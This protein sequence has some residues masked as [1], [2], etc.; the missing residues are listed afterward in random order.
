M[1]SAPTSPMYGLR[2]SPVVNAGEVVG[3]RIVEMSWFYGLDDLGLRTG[4]LVQ[5]IDGVRVRTWNDFVFATQRLA[6]LPPGASFV[7][8]IRRDQEPR[9]LFYRVGQG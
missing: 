4:D 5:E 9:T 8:R 7:V 3:H 1:P 2:V 6:A